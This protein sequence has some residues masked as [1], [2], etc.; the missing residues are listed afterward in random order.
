MADRK[1][2]L[3][4]TDLRELEAERKLGSDN[5]A[6]GFKEGIEAAKEAFDKMRELL[7]E[8]KESQK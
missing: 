4:S 1:L 3:D 5:N 2:S 8:R 6:E 7:T